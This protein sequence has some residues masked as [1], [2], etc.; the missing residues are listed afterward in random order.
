MPMA[1]I[2]LLSKEICFLHADDNI[3]ANLDPQ[4]VPED[5]ENQDAPLF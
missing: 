1:S 3:I 2:L 4:C 5:Q